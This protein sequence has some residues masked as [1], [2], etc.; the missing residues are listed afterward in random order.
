MYQLTA[1]DIRRRNR[2]YVLQAVYAAEG[3]TSRQEI[4]RATG[5]SFAT[6]GNMIAELLD[7][8]V[9]AELGYDAPGVGRP[10]AQLAINPER[11][12]LVG[13]DI[14]ETSIHFD[15]FDLAM[16]VLRSVE[17]PVDPQATQPDDVTE[18]IV[19]GVR[20][21]TGEDAERVL[22]VGLSV[23]GL[24]EPEGGV[25]VF[26]PYWH[27][28][29]VSLKSLLAPRIPHP[30]YL[31]NPLKASTAA[32]LWFGAGRDVDDLIVV[33][34]RAGVG[35]GVV[36]DG[37]LYRGVT[38]SAG[39]WGHTNLVLDGRL[40]RCGR[41]GCVEAYVSAPGIVQT[42]RESD[43]ASSLFG[44]DDAATIT[45]IA[46]AAAREDATAVEVIEKTGHYLGV[47]V[48][49]LVNLF[50]PRTMVFGDLVANVLGER[51]LEVTR[52]V[53]AHHAMSDPYAAVTLQLC[54]LPHNPSS[55]GAATFALEGFLADRE[56]F[57]S[58]AAR[59]AIRTTTT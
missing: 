39:E 59:R 22:G 56:T 17:I 26:S 13:V 44:V 21:L 55:L 46:A 1:R 5:L 25:S 32:H 43:P 2:F 28:H 15:L 41:H 45:A 49:N 18:L 34:L 50:N 58:I 24:V 29:D 6:V 14:A 48:A 53:A 20:E 31:D 10:R 16:T 27:W 40:C 57:G 42:L 7:V 33:T 54:T 4:A 8:G 3:H 11:G 38:N 35:I 37:T 23:P 30:L 19:R 12:M 36:I 9:L 47:A 51:L 52:R